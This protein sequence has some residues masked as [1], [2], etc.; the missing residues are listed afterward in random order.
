LMTQEWMQMLSDSCQRK[1]RLAADEKKKRQVVV[2]PSLQFPT[3][4]PMY[5]ERK[6]L[7]GIS[8]DT[9]GVRQH[10]ADTLTLMWNS[11]ELKTSSSAS[12]LHGV[13]TGYDSSMNFACV[14]CALNDF[15]PGVCSV[16]Y[17]ESASSSWPPSSWSVGLGFARRVAA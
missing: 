10:R 8:F 9:Q 11:K 5:P 4:M 1:Q 12:I 15:D 6:D 17:V 13:T 16:T 14:A 7:T 3:L 2:R